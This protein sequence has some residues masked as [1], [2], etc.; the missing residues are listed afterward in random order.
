MQRGR[1]CTLSIPDLHAPYQHP[2]ALQFVADCLRRYKPTEVVYLGDEIDA[3]RFSHYAHDPDLPGPEDELRLAVKQLKRFYRLTPNA[4]VCHSNHTLRLFKR[5]LGAG[6]PA[7]CLRG[8]SEILEAPKTW[9]WADSFTIDDVRYIHGD[10][11][12]GVNAA[13]NAAMRHR[14]NIVMGHCHSNAGVWFSS[15][16]CDTI[17]GLAAGCLL[18]DSALCFAYGRNS[19]RRPV[20]GLGVVDEGVPMFVPMGAS[21]A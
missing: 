10:G 8:V 21:Y 15:G 4:K 1:K 12:A 2:G 17:F 20:L 5:A 3:H 13:Q 19:P 6:I 7:R 16:L 18:D 11:F 14:C 9:Q